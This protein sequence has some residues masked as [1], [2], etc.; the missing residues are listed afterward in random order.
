M[1]VQ[2]RLLADTRVRQL[3][4]AACESYQLAADRQETLRAFLEERFRH[5]MSSG[6]R[7]HADDAIAALERDIEDRALLQEALGDSAPPA[8]RAI[9]WR[10]FAVLL[11]LTILAYDLNLIAQLWWF[12]FELAGPADVSTL[13]VA[14]G[15]DLISGGLIWL[16][17]ASARRWPQ[18]RFGRQMHAGHPATLL[19]ATFALLLANVLIPVPVQSQGI[20]PAIRFARS[21]IYMVN[22]NHIVTA[23][24][25]FSAWLWWYDRAP[26]A[27]QKVIVVTAAFVLFEAAYGM[28]FFAPRVMAPL[29]QTFGGGAVASSDTMIPFNVWGIPLLW[30]Y[31]FARPWAD[32]VEIGMLRYS[33]SLG[34]AGIALGLYLMLARA[35]R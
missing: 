11:P 7:R 2:G 29:G 14:F 18:S 33:Y 8:L 24:F 25:A 23:I 16:C 4:D 3:I 5:Y 9:Q 6:E 26:H 34:S 1:E 28:L 15:T 17:L 21:Y 31:Q 27:Y 12:V 10:R 32:M 19:L 30:S 20:A 35:E 22:W 13:S